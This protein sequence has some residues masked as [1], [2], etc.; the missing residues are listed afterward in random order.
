MKPINEC[1][2]VYELLESPERWIK[3]HHYK[4]ENGEEVNHVNSVQEHVYKERAI[5]FCLEGAIFH[6]Y[7]YATEASKEAHTKIETLL[8]QIEPNKIGVLIP[9][10]NDAPERTHAEVLEAVRKAGI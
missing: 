7:G 9:Y 4:L 5:C 8:Q 10:F 3:K 2:T 1:K 6:C